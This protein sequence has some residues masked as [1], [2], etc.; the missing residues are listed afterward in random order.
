MELIALLLQLSD[1]LAVFV[2]VDETLGEVVLRVVS[3]PEGLQQQRDE[4][5]NV[6]VRHSDLEDDCGNIQS[7]SQRCRCTEKI[8]TEVSASAF[9]NHNKCQQLLRA[10]GGEAPLNG[11][12]K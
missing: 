4:S 5:R 6:V 2:F 10:L 12:L 11:D 9:L 3:G 1:L 7:S 8:A